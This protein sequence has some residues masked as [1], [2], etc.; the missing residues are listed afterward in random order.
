MVA[1]RFTARAGVLDRLG[2][3]AVEQEM[4]GHV[5]G[6]HVAADPTGATAVPGV[7]VAGN[8]ADLTAQVIGAAAGGCA[9]RRGDQRRP[10]PGGD[11]AS[12]AA[13]ACR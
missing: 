13:R 10:G 4:D 6:T 12:R 2:L 8:V 1:P 5:V 11:G 7:W 3:E 9:R